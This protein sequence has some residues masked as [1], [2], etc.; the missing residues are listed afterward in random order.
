MPQ[1]SDLASHPC[2]SKKA[3][4]SSI[5]LVC[6]HSLKDPSAFLELLLDLQSPASWTQPYPHPSFKCRGSAVQAPVPAAWRRR[7]LKLHAMETY[8]RAPPSP[9]H[10]Y[11]IKARQER[12]A[13]LRRFILLLHSNH[14]D[15]CRPRLQGTKAR[16]KPGGAQMAFP[17][18]D[19]RDR[20]SRPG[21]LRLKRKGGYLG[22]EDAGAQTARS[23][24]RAE[25]AAERGHKAR[26]P[27]WEGREA[28]SGAPGA[29]SLSVD[30][31]AARAPPRPRPQLGRLRL[32]LC[33][34]QGLR[35]RGGSQSGS[36]LCPWNAPSVRL[37]R[38]RS[39]SGT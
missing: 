22:M 33:G 12:H 18:G 34:S 23:P 16:W 25:S 38:A 35:P 5:F 24:G 2:P 26:A 37:A 8:L 11:E 15:G 30:S 28:G 14:G 32:R 39:V 9:T 29:G 17:G 36:L 6:F 7:C 13:V 31:A 20:Q 4:H 3:H 27:A 21:K 1:F 10:L 19:T